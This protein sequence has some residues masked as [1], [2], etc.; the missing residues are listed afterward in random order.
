[1]A[2]TLWGVAATKRGVALSRPKSRGVVLDLE[3]LKT[4]LQE[5]WD[6]LTQEDIRRII[7]SMPE[8]MMEA[9][10]KNGLATKF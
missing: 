4:A 7:I 10:E 8:R 2:L 9:Y 1:M 3:G 6:N 5:E